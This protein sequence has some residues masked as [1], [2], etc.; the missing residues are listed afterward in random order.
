MSC[1]E[2]E[3]R[4][5]FYACDELDAAERAALEEHLKV[6]PACAAALEGER[7]LLEAA[8]LAEPLEPS[9]A[10]L[11][12]CRGQLGDALDLAAERAWWKGV[13]GVLNPGNWLALHPAWGAA[14]LV[15][16]GVTTG[17]LVPRWLEPR[18]SVPG[19]PSK[20]VVAP[21]NATNSPR[22]ISDQDLRNVGVAGINWVPGQPGEPPSVEVHLTAEQPMVLRGTVDSSEVKR[23]LM[24]VVENNHRFDPGV[25]LDSVELLKS[26]GNDADVR[27][28]LCYAARNDR[29]TGV[30]LKS[31]EALR[32]FEQDEEVRQVLLDALQHDAN[33]GL[34]VEAINALRAMA[35]QAPAL[36]DE[37]VLEVLKDRMQKD[38]STYIRLQ[39]AAAIRRLGPREVY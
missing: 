39:S 23:V 26:R 35:E 24:F 8:T 1:Q 5:V 13:L 21:T 27:H 28:A 37:R 33:P 30:R 36:S 4:V 2:M 20:A 7:R 17:Y 19:A 18:P 10:L 14:L 3:Q 15:L 16:L 12:G 32:G 6:C 22:P 11:A 38:P 25:R 31:L 34:R 29:N 9:E